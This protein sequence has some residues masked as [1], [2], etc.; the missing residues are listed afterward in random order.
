MHELV[1]NSNI[2]RLILS[3]SDGRQHVWTMIL[4]AL[5]SCYVCTVH[6]ITINSPLSGMQGGWGLLHE[7]NSY[8][9]SMQSEDV[10]TSVLA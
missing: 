9:K 1:G 5:Q 7:K 2:T 3:S 4:R 8:R 10:P 6:E